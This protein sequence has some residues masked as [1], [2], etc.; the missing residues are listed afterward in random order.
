MSRSKRNTLRLREISEDAYTH[1]ELT[2]DRLI[3][4]IRLLCSSGVSDYT[5]ICDSVLWSGTIDDDDY[6][7][8]PC[9]LYACTSIGG[10]TIF[11]S[12][13][14]Y[15]G[16]STEENPLGKLRRYFSAPLSYYESQLPVTKPADIGMSILINVK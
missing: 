5:R 9:V 2:S 11:V 7:E 13:S 4:Y 16:Y 1:V 12:A 10:E 3:P 8:A 14:L 15:D 6:L